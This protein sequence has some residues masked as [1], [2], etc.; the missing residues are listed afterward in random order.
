MNYYF[1]AAAALSL[2]GAGFHIFVGNKRIDNVIFA[3]NIDIHVRTISRIV[4]HS[5]TLILLNSFLFLLYGAINGLS[6]ELAYFMTLYQ[7]GFS[8]LFL[9]FCGI[10][11]KNPI[12]F[13]HPFVFA[14]MGILTI[15]GAV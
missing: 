14:L 4:W 8:L 12:R 7:F 1:L 15:L 3:T 11:L 13:P 10:H 2:F 9:Y 6:R 5:V